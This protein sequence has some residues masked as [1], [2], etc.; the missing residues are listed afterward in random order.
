MQGLAEVCQDAVSLQYRSIDRI[1]LNV[2]IPTLQTP[3]AMAVFFREVRRQPI[4]AGK[5]F[6]DL[7]DGFVG[8]VRQFVQQSSN[9]RFQS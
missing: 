3:A 1:V 6:K 8:R 2:Y 9:N 7:T 5:A 4:L